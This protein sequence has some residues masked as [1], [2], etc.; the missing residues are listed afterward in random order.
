MRQGHHSMVLRAGYFWCIKIHLFLPN[1]SLEISFVIQTNTVEISSVIQTNA[2]RGKGREKQNPHY[3]LMTKLHSAREHTI[4]DQ[5][6]G[7]RHWHLSEKNHPLWSSR[8]F[9]SLWGLEGWLAG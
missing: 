3:N 2:V 5:S 4:L 1:K 6:S 8:Y 9:S 7:G